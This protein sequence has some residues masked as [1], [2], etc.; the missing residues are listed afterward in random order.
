[1]SVDIFDKLV[2]DQ[3]SDKTIDKI[4]K[5][6][7]ASYFKKQIALNKSKIIYITNNKIILFCEV[8]RVQGR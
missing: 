1:M 6:Y 2:T 7:Q 8:Y 5:F 3:Q 4:F